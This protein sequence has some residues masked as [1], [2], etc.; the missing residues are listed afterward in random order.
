M[1]W[2][3]GTDRQLARWRKV[4]PGLTV[5]ASYPTLSGAQ[6]GSIP[7]LVFLTSLKSLIK[8]LLTSLKLYHFV[9]VN[10]MIKTKAND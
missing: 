4:S 9:D 3:P 6:A 8:S 1:N 10:K 2:Q 7:A 5:Y